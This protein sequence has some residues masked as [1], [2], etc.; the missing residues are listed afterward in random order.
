MEKKK[1]YKVVFML[2]LPMALQNLI[3]VGVTAAD[4]IMLGEV[5]ETALS[6]ASL[7]NQVTFIL[8][9]ILFGLTSGAAVL[10]AQ[11]WGKADI[12]TIEKVM[13][14]SLRFG[15][16]CGTAFMAAALFAPHYLMRLFTNEQAVIAEGARYLKI[17]AIS[18]IPMSLNMV[19]LNIV[20]SVERVVAATVTY[21]ISLLVNVGLNAVF[22]FGLCGFPAM[23]VAGA[24]L[25]TLC[26]RICESLIVLIHIK[27]INNTF[28]LRIRDMVIRDKALHADFIKYAGPVIINELI[29]GTGMAMISA[30]IGRLGTAAVSA[31]AVASTSRQ[32][33]TVLA[34][35][36][37]GA[38]AIMLGKT[39]G[40][41]KEAL[42]KEYAGRFV[43]LSFITGIFGA[44][45]IL[46]VSPVARHFMNL[47][48]QAKEYLRYMMYVMAYF[49]FLQ[50]INCDIIVG[51]CRSG[52]D[53]KIGLVLDTVTLWGGSIVLGM[54]AAF[55]FKLPVPLVYVF[56]VSDEVLKFPFAW[57]RYR[58][59]KWLKNI[60][61]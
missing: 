8:N 14:I 54:A 4:V 39:I 32:L 40:E 42:A 13:G 51:I 33:A 48:W 12:R 41:G 23:G 47:T 28:S 15:L 50:S 17:V 1:F 58:S 24:A 34:M 49:C 25:G 31:H 6:G 22:I 7:A 37:A 59:M 26:A 21:A 57:Q 55:V 36:V 30:V 35:G 45:V 38:T 20:R 10:T 19:Y 43:K 60:T 44:L 3:N 18:Y 46:G 5:G 56:L 29:W 61:R 52:G 16:L 2:V 27:K 9:L 53:T 11:Y